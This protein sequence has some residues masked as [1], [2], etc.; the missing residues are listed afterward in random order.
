MTCKWCGVPLKPQQRWR[1]RTYCS[2]SC[3]KTAFHADHPDAARRAGQLSYAKVG[4]K[5]YIERLKTALAGCKSLGEAYRRGYSNGYKVGVT[6][7][8]RGH[9]SLK[10]IAA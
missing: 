3:A 1:R 10:G 5:K 9:S 8:R 2:R 7:R 6:R 4:R